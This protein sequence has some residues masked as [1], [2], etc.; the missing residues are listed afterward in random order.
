MNICN[1]YSE[2]YLYFWVKTDIIS[3]CNIQT[4]HIRKLLIKILSLHHRIKTWCDEGKMDAIFSKSAT[5]NYPKT[6][7]RINTSEKT[8]K[9]LFC[10]IVLRLIYY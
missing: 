10:V 3:N 8:N 2:I 5:P 7:F 9:I 6:T 4:S 1:G